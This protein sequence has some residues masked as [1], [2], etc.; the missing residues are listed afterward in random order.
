MLSAQEKTAINRLLAQ[1]GLATL[2]DPG[3]VNQLGFLMSQAIRNHGDFRAM[4]NRCEPSERCNLYESMKPYLRFN[5]K[6]LDVYVAELGMMAEAKRLP[7]IQADGTLRPFKPAEIESSCGDGCNGC[8]R[9]ADL[10]VRDLKVAQ[11]AIAEAVAKY[12][13]TLVCKQCT[14]EE[15]FPGITKPEALKRAREAGWKLDE[16]SEKEICPGCTS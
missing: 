15:S 1:N 9:C 7:I 11:D 12:H 8:R 2:D 16:V 6:P 10:K 14:R 13:L 4:L 5:V 3:L